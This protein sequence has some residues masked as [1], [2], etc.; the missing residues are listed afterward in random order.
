MSRN[1]KRQAVIIEGQ[2]FDSISKAAN[3]VGADVSC[4]RWALKFNKNRKY[5]NLTVSFAD[6]AKEAEVVASFDKVKEARKQR[7]IAHRCKKLSAKCSPIYCENLDKTFKTIKS[8][9]KFA[10]TSTYT[11][12]TK[13]EV[14]GRFVDKAGNVYKRIKPMNSTKQYKNTGDKLK[15]DRVSGYT[16]A[17]SVKSTETASGI[18]L[19]QTI[20]KGK[21]ID[22]IQQNKFDV[23]KE[24]LDIVKKIEG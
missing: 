10:G 23:A 13:T 16:R 8:A 11:M 19:A 7:R 9:A 3:Y 15:F 2:V 1:N 17:E 12:S 18:Q 21:A 6:P 22:Y 14:A 20:L 5:K 4:I 24:L